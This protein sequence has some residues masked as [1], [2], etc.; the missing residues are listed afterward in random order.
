MDTNLISVVT[1]CF[2]AE[3][4]I[5]YTI[6]SI[7]NQDYA[8]Y[9]YLIKDGG[10][11]DS[12]IQIAEKYKDKFK[13]KNISFR[14]VSKIDNGIYDAMNKALEFI[15]GEWVI[16]INAGDAL[17]D[18]HTLSKLSEDVSPEYDILYGNAVLTDRGKYKLLKAGVEE[19]WQKTNPMCHQA[20]LTRTDVVRK[21]LFDTRYE[22]SADYDLSLRIYLADASRLKR[23]DYVMSIFMFGGMSDSKIF[24]REKEFN[25]SRKI[26]GLKRVAFPGLLIFKNV[27]VYVIRRWATVILKGGFYSKKRGWYSTKTEAAREGARK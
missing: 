10:S 13:E 5:E 20:T 18:N 2:N 24:K 19:D 21:F 1:V 27:M 7:L 6:E 11:L 4:D 8:H 23:L 3:K 25:E 9:E 15:S 17:Y 26:N 14:I 22:I 16:Y 12:T